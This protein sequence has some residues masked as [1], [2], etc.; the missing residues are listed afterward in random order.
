MCRSDLGLR[1]APV[2][3]VHTHPTESQARSLS[4]TDSCFW[5]IFQVTSFLTSGFYSV[6]AGTTS[7]IKP[8]MAMDHLYEHLGLLRKSQSIDPLAPFTSFNLLS[9][10]SSSLLRYLPNAC[11]L[12]NLER[13]LSSSQP[14]ALFPF[15]HPCPHLNFCSSSSLKAVL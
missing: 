3:Q 10:T 5:L 11:Y 2:R 7:Q 14:P 9:W 4:G 15:L 1:P 13:P 8:E 6:P 12:Q